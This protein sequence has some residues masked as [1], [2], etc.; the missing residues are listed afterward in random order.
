MQAVAPCWDGDIE[1]VDASGCNGR[2]SAAQL[3][4]DFLYQ[5]VDYLA[6]SLLAARLL[7]ISDTEHQLLLGIDHLV[8]DGV[9]SG[10]VSSEL[11]SLYR[12]AEKEGVLPQPSASPIHYGDYAMWQLE[13]LEQW[14]ELHEPYWRECVANMRRTEFVYDGEAPERAPLRWRMTE[15]PLGRQLS[16]RL[17]I[18]AASTGMTLPLV[19]LG[20]IVST[21]SRWCGQTR[22]TVGMVNHGRHGHPE[23]TYAVGAI[24]S[25]LPL[26]FSARADEPLL[27]TIKSIHVEN[28]TA[29]VHQDYGRLCDSSLPLAGLIPTT[30]NW[31]PTAFGQR[32]VR[33]GGDGAA[34]AQIAPLFLYQTQGELM[35]PLPQLNFRVLSEGENIGDGIVIGVIHQENVFTPATISSLCEAVRQFAAAFAAD[36]MVKPASLSVAA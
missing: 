19:M 10:I 34:G 21:L 4:S 35:G 13:G 29:L 17:K 6:G 20:L 5:K 31:V 3:A 11:T 22:W 8:T 16:D 36:P 1:L 14:R 12:H 15:F 24:L 26:C 2:A 18:T 7:R 30:Y 32:Q 27:E 9:S 23:L 28:A 33:P 25:L